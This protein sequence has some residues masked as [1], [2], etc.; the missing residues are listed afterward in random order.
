MADETV[1]VTISYCAECGYE[2]AALS[3]TE[4]LMIH[5]KE[6]LSSI[7]LIPWYEGSFDVSVAD[8]LVHSM[9]RDGGFPENQTIGQAVREHLAAAPAS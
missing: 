2:P 6:R 5:F 9:Y 7:E 3:L 8:E 4:Y 1:K